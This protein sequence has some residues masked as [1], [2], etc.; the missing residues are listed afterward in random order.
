MVLS[1]LAFTFSCGA[2]T[3]M[4]LDGGLLKHHGRNI[5]WTASDFPIYILI[6]DQLDDTLVSSIDLAVYEWNYQVGFSLFVTD[7]YDFRE[8]APRTSGFI[9]VSQKDLGKSPRNP[10]ANVLGLASPYLHESSSH[11]KAVQVWYDD[12]ITADNALLIM[13]HELGHALGLAHDNDCSSIMHPH[14]VNCSSPEIVI[15]EEDI[16]RIRNMR[17]RTHREFQISNISQLPENWRHVRC[18]H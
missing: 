13:L 2:S 4:P 15:K 1:V 5:Y 10:E 18:T 3:P 16:T 12:S 14:V 8:P 7:I 17:F 11:I 9:A 6:D